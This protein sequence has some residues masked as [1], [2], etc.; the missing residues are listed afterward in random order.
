MS[1]SIHYTTPVLS[2]LVLS[3]LTVYIM[4]LSFRPSQ[5]ADFLSHYSMT[6]SHTYR[7]SRIYTYMYM[8]I[9]L[10]FHSYY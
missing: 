8:Y 5:S 3:V 10:Y 6:H 2:C 7:Q 9:H 4:Y 1:V